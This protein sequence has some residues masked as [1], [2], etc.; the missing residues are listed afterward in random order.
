MKNTVIE[1]W[2]GLRVVYKQLE[3]HGYREHLSEDDARLWLSVFKSDI[4]SVKIGLDLLLQEISVIWLLTKSG[5]AIPSPF[6][7]VC[8]FAEDIESVLSEAYKPVE[9]IGEAA[10][11]LKVMES[12]SWALVT[13]GWTK[14]GAFLTA[15]EETESW[16]IL[17][18]GQLEKGEFERYLNRCRRSPSNP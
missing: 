18:Q 4:F 14:D 11:I 6:L 9:T 16:A 8:F 10:S 12:H 3:A 2:Q 17:N 15:L 13:D 1:L 5:R 7:A